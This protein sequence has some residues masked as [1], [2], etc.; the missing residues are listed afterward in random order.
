MDHLVNHMNGECQLWADDKVLHQFIYTILLQTLLL[1][2]SGLQ[3]RVDLLSTINLQF[4]NSA[5]L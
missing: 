4:F 2:N 1:N 5:K 3:P